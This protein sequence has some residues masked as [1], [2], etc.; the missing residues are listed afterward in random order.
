[1]SPER[2][3]TYAALGGAVTIIATWAAHAF[4]GVDVP[5]EV[6]QAVTLIVATLL[7]HF[8]SDAKPDDFSHLQ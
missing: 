8:V 1:M 3:T 6:G 2:S 4:A 7:A 5:A